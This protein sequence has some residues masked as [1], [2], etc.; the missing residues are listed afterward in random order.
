M[1][2]FVEAVAE[3]SLFLLALLG[4]LVDPWN[5]AIPERLSGPSEFL[6]T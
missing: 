6:S 4:F 2:L 1:S 3:G 5:L